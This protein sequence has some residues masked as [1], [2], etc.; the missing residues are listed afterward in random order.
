MLTVRGA[1]ATALLALCVAA[2]TA[3][4]HQ[5]NPNYRSQVRSI[6][7]AVDGLEAQVL[8]YDDR[9]ELRNEGDNTVVVEGYRGEPYLRFEPDGTVEVNRR[10][11][12]VYLNEVRFAKVSV[13]GSADPSAPPEWEVVSKT[14][15][16]DWHDHRIH[17]MG[18]TPPP[19]VRKNEKARTK[20]FDWKLPIAAAGQ[21]SVIRGSLVWVGKDSG[22]FPLAAV[23]SLLA[24][25]LGGA[26]LVVFVRRR[27]RGPSRRREVEAW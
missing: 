23:V 11:P 13:P 8:G 14:G 17:W 16:Y 24:A 7:P 15:R 6:T 10:S 19:M 2:P 18:A 20:V 21:R 22:G 3:V 26:A 12:A 25:I 5:G 4:A 9:I 1:A 27:R